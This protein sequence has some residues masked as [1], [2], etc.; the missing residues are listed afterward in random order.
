[1][2]ALAL[3]IGAAAISYIAVIYAKR[4]ALAHQIMD[5]PNARSSHSRPMPRAGGIGIVATSYT[6]VL[7]VAA[8]HGALGTPTLAVLAGGLA[9]AIVGLADDLRN[10]PAWIR[11]SVHVLAA[12]AIVF[13]G[14]RVDTISLLPVGSLSLG[15]L[16]A[17]LSVVWIVAVTNIYNFMDGIDGLAAGVA[18]LAGVGLAT[19]GAI[20]GDPAILL[21]SCTLAGSALGFLAHNF[22]PASVF[23]GDV[24]SG[25]LGFV[26]AA[27]ILLAGSTSSD[28]GS[29][30]P[31]G[32]VIAPFLL[33]G[34][35]TLVRRV[36]QGER[37]Y[38]AH[39]SHYYQRLV[40]LG[41]SHR[42]VSLLYYGLTMLAVL[43]AIA[44]VVFPGLT[45]L[46]L[47]LASIAPFF[48]LLIAVPRWESRPAGPAQSRS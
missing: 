4:W 30:I 34:T 36:I 45:G 15:F 39:R 20:R 22:P 23:M 27:L 7:I 10:L 26:L 40:I 25:F 8:I 32:L 16:G 31:A 6:L 48:I 5:I 42:A 38:E 12:S 24:G 47:M 44:Y 46:L 19:M 9:V 29:A 11:F 13:L 33:D 28:G 43:G 14:V 1:V 17:I 37:W 21:L 35:L 3:L 2:A 18:V 41:Y